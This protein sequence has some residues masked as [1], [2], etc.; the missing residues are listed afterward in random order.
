ILRMKHGQGESLAEAMGRLYADRALAQL[1]S[2]SAD[3]VLPIPLHWRR[4]FSRGYNQSA[5]LS[6]ALARAL[7][8][9]HRPRWLRRIVATPRQAA[10]MLP[11]VRRANLRDAF[12]ASAYADLKGK[13]VLLVDDVMTTGATAHEASRA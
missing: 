7:N 12:R 9:P 3:V 8:K 5:A 6:A 1:Q 11:T 13:L 2:L 4:R 10:Q